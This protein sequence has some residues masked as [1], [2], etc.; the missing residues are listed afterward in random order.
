MQRLAGL[1]ASPAHTVVL[2]SPSARDPQASTFRDVISRVLGRDAFAQQ[3]RVYGEDGELWLTPFEAD[4]NNDT[5]EFNA[6]YWDYETG[7]Y[8]SIDLKLDTPDMTNYPVWGSNEYIMA[9]NEDSRIKS[10]SVAS[11]LVPTLYAQTHYE[12][13]PCSD[14][15]A[16][17]AKFY[18]QHKSMVQNAWIAAGSAAVPCIGATIGWIG[19]VGG[20]FSG[21]YVSSMMWYTGNFL[22]ACRCRYLGMHCP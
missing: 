1:G 7:F 20:A 12:G 22:Y 11:L 10:P 15:Q 17:N 3:E 5:A 14:T 9:C 16:M 18:E 19:C 6:Y 13:T 2:R 21:G 4:G 8:S